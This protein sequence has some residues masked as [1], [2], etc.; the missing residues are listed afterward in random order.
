[1]VIDQPERKKSKAEFRR[2]RPL[3]VRFP[4]PGNSK[5]YPFTR[6]AAFG[7]AEIKCLASHSH[8]LRHESGFT[9]IGNFGTRRQG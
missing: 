8:G 2:T 3:S 5:T 1:M 4:P 7:A 6:G 9:V